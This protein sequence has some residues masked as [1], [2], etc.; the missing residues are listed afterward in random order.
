MEH[1]SHGNRFR[2]RH[3]HPIQIH[4]CFRV[5]PQPSFYCLL[6]IISLYSLCFF[7]AFLLSF[8]GPHPRHMEV[9]R[10]GVE[11]E[12]QLPAYT[13][14]TAP[15]DPSHICELHHSSR[16]RWILNPLREAR[17]RTHILMD[18][19]RVREPLHHGG[20]SQPLGSTLP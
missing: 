16:Q 15:Q 3:F 7:V 14:A 12:L 1:N 5:R 6:Y 9:P 10:I 17:D 19:T 2:G 13:T 4:F 18:A 8:T 20:N 11:S